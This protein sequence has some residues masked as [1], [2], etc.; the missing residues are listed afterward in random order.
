VT[1]TSSPSA[2]LG[3]SWTLI[4]PPLRSSTAAL[5]FSAARCCAL[6]SGRSWWNYLRDGGAGMDQRGEREA[7]DQRLDSAAFELLDHRGSPD[8]GGR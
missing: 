1:S 3:N 4:A 5:N 6:S 2:L 8:W 7:A